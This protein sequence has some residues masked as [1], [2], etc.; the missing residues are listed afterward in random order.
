MAIVMFWDATDSWL[1][2]FAERLARELD[3]KTE[4]TRI[5]RA[6]TGFGISAIEELPTK[7]AELRDQGTSIH[8]MIVVTHG[9]PGK[10]RFASSYLFAEGIIKLLSGRGFENLFQPG[11]RV[12]FQGCSLAK[13]PDGCYLGDCALTENGL[14]FLDTFARTLLTNG[15]RV[16]AWD[17]TGY[18]F[19]IIGTGDHH[20]NGSIHHII[21]KRGRRNTRYAIGSEEASPVGWWTVSVNKTSYEY[22]FFDTY[23]VKFRTIGGGEKGS[24]V[25]AWYNGELSIRWSIGDRR[26]STPHG[27]LDEKEVWD[28][29]L[30]NKYQTGKAT[31]NLR[32]EYNVS[33]IRPN[34]TRM[35]N[36]WTGM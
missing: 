14:V 22:Q 4:K 30:F 34:Y 36:F 33:A 6:Y 19:R 26:W 20:F 18:S 12:E 25:W 3:V 2:D 11:A 15:G 13:I 35:W 21:N 9:N 7:F 24:G 17:S 32:A 8:R 28:L 29:P 16:S 10:I 31:G 23:T 27:P 1:P 5:T